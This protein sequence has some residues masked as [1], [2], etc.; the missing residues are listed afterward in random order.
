M[1]ISAQESLVKLLVAQNADIMVSCLP[2][3]YRLLECR[4]EDHR[5]WLQNVINFLLQPEHQHHIINALSCTSPKVARLALQLIIK[6]NLLSTEEIIQRCL[7]H[8]DPVVRC[9]AVRHLPDVS[10]HISEELLLIALRDTSHSVRLAAFDSLLKQHSELL[11]INIDRLLFDANASIRMRT[12]ELLKQSNKNAAEHYLLSLN[13]SDIT[14]KKTSYALWGLGVIRHPEA[15]STASRFIKHPY[16]KVRCMALQVIVWLVEEDRKENLISAVKDDFPSV[17]KEAVR[18][19]NK[20]KVSLS[21]DELNYL[22]SNAYHVS[23]CY[24]L[25]YRLSKWDRLIFLLSQLANEPNQIAEGEL[26]RWY[27]SYNNIGTQPTREQIVYL[28]ELLDIINPPYNLSLHNDLNEI[29][30][31]YYNG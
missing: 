2:E 29:V 23:G 9:I 3:L 12:I 14:A 16:T 20:Y 24:G 10:Q 5:D 21:L 31:F 19:I 15:L 4:R 26:R 7:Q 1:R 6:Y 18:L 28:T 25:L 17:V 11:F 8:Q 30:K 13:C 22:I 27:M